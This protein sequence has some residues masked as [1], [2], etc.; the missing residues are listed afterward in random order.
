[1]KLNYII[2]PIIMIT[3]SSLG[4][5]FTNM[6][7]NW[8]DNLIKPPL[9]LSGQIIGTVWTVIFILAT[10]SALICWN[11]FPRGYRFKWIFIFFI[12]NAVLNTLWSLLFFTLNFV[13]LSIFEMILLNATTI[14]LT[15]LIWPKSRLAASLLIPYV[16]WVSF[17][18]FLAYG[19]FLLNPQGL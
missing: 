19:I 13:F 11:S 18:T 7:M 5:I 12:A 15:I 1:M 10:T 14:V 4:V 9:T 3:I 16:I 6:G 17:A 8:Y 2:I